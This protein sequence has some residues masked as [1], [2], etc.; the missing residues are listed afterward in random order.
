MLI[1]KIQ[2]YERQ[3]FVLILCKSFPNYSFM[4][5]ETGDPEPS[6]FRRA[7]PQFL[8]VT[9][10]NMLMLGNFAYFEEIRIF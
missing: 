3:K 9:V 4:D 7:L 6:K 2:F 8:A 1:G 10:K 5:N